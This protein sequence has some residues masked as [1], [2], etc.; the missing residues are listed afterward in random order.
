MCST[1]IATASYTTTSTRTTAT[2][3]PPVTTNY[4]YCYYVERCTAQASGVWFLVRLLCRLGISKQTILGGLEGLAPEHRCIASSVEDSSR[5]PL[6][7][8]EGLSYCHGEQ[9]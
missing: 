7:K 6:Q 3:P 1:A 4:S 5:G 2:P 9:G 8:V